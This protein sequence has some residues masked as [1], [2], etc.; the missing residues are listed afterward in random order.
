MEGREREKRNVNDDE[1]K[2]D[3]PVKTYG[4]AS[5]LNRGK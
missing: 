3:V 2:V 4:V 1:R 5:M